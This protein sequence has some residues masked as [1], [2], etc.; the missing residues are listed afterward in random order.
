MKANQILAEHVRT[1]PAH[2]WIFPRVGLYIPSGRNI[3]SATAHSIIDF[4]EIH[5]LPRY[6]IGRGCQLDMMRSQAAAEFLKSD[7]THLLFLDD[8]HCHPYQIL[9]KLAM[10]V[11]ETVGTENE[12][13]VIG[14]MNYKRSYPHQPCV[15]VDR[16]ESDP[17]Q[18]DAPPDDI[19]E[20]KLGTPVTW[21]PGRLMRAAI[22]GTGS[23]LVAREVFEAMEYP[24]FW[25]PIEWVR[26]KPA[27]SYPGEDIGFA[28]AC[29]KLGIAQFCDTSCVSPHL[30]ERFAAAADFVPSPPCESATTS[31]PPATI[32]ST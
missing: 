32:H 12:I 13:Q 8:D 27:A 15:W 2:E 6:D 18:G 26:N 1:H 28:V 20:S 22:I 17:W 11:A 4:C 25:S 23:M 29:R 7:L 21:T 16:D 5:R 3:P 10:S 31:Q 19:H 30:G 24:Y 9:N 14:G